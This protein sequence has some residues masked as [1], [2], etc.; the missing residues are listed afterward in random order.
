MCD[1]LL[2]SCIYSYMVYGNGWL[3]D[4]NNGMWLRVLDCVDDLDGFFARTTCEQTER[5]KGNVARYIPILGLNHPQT[6]VSM[7][8]LSWILRNKRAIL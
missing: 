4:E 3:N 6:L 5:Y 1:D 2:K 8:N 7:N